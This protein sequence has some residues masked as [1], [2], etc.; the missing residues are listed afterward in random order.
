MTAKWCTDCHKSDNRAPLKHCDTRGFHLRGARYETGRTQ[1]HVRSDGKPPPAHAARFLH[2]LDAR[3]A[4]MSEPHWYM[5]IS[6]S[7][8]RLTSGA[9]FA[10]ASFQACLVS[11]A[12][13]YVLSLAASSL[14]KY[15][16]AV[17]LSST[18]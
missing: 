3:L 9:P 17:L 15:R 11:L 13:T 5:V 12:V 10:P 8:T 16:Y 18:S 1:L 7:F 14:C 2:A 4:V 6:P